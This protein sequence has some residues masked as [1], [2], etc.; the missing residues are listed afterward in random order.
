MFKYIFFIYNNFFYIRFNEWHILVTLSGIFS[1]IKKY[2]CVTKRRHN[3]KNKFSLFKFHCQLLNSLRF[4]KW[5][6]LN[7]ELRF[8]T[9]YSLR[10]KVISNIKENRII[11]SFY[12]NEIMLCRNEKT[13]SHQHYR[14]TILLREK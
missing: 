8:L 1:Y 10:M 7:C 4:C 2:K 9:M 5:K 6:L 14:I 12:F 3:L 11:I 13:S